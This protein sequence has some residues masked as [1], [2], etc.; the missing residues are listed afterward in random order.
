MA[1]TASRRPATGR[2][3]STSGFPDAS[4][5]GVPSGTAL[6]TRERRNFASSI[7]GQI[8]DAHDVHGTITVDHPGVIIRNCEARYHRQCRQRHDRRQYRYRSEHGRQWHHLLA[9]NATVQRCDISGAEN[10]IWLEANWLF[11][12]RQLHSRLDAYVR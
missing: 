11:D 6:T 4:T 8:I 1:R 9:D 7:A 2:E 12:R 10:G 3:H 5:T